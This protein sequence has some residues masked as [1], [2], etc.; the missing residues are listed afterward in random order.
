MISKLKSI[1]YKIVFMILFFVL[2]KSCVSDYFNGG[3]KGKISN[4]T[5]MI[6]EDTFVIANL[7]NEYKETTLARV[8]KLYEF[9]YSFSLNGN[10]YSGDISLSNLPNTNQLKLYYLS[11]NP[12][13][14]SANPNND[15]K[16]EKEKGESIS[17]L[18]VGIVWGILSLVMLLGLILSFKKSNTEN[19]KPK[20]PI[21]EYKSIHNIEI[22]KEEKLKEQIEKE[23][24]KKEKEDPN[25]FMPK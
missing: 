17:D 15:L 8:V 4:L 18:L 5:Q 1:L 19:N 13:F 7:A 22:S 3:D 9:N 21:K 10:L 16:S 11:S 12:N 6:E 23:R 25:R 14:V 24:I 20:Q 2:A